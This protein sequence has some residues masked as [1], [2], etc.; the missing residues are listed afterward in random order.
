MGEL[1]LIIIAVI[2]A[3]NGDYTFFWIFGGIAVFA[4]IVSLFDNDHG[5]SVSR[6]RPRT[7]IDI[8]HIYDADDYECSV[9]HRRFQENQMTCPHCGAQFSG[10]VTDTEEW[11][12]EEDELEAWDEEEGL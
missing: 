12:E 11:D 10:N 3:A 4:L 7:R 6:R 2:L 1:I 8:P 9:C 5:K